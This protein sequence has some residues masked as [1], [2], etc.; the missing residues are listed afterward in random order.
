M[1]RRNWIRMTGLML[2]GCVAV[3]GHAQAQTCVEPPNGI[4]AWWPGDG[5]STDLHG[6]LHAVAAG[7][8]GY[9]PGLVGDA[10][11]LDGLAGGQDDRVAL[12]PGAVNGLHDLTLE[13]WVNTQDDEA[14]LFSGASN[15]EPFTDNEL[16]L[17]QGTGG[18]IGFMKQEHTGFLPVFLN[19]GAWHHVAFTRSGSLGTLYIDGAVVDA[20]GFPAGA[21]EIGHGGLMLGQE[22]DCLAGCLD[23]TQAFDGLID[24]VSIYERALS[25]AEITSLFDAGSA[26][27][28]KPLSREDLQQNVADLEAQVETL[29]ARIAE[30]EA[31]VPTDSPEE[32]CDDRKPRHERKRRWHHRPRR[33]SRTHR[34]QHHK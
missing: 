26:G 24:E 32:E 14:A 19:D 25:D 31:T 3:A 20:R 16:V 22:Q 11:Q 30:L 8:T 12:P 15:L 13:M 28:C 10:F 17:Y 7:G 23:P 1:D 5:D 27:K 9:A 2:S 18:T 21:F 34:H 29:E 6:G 33:H 4:V